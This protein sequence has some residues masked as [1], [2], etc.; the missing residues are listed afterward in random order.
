MADG[1]ALVVTAKSKEPA[2]PSGYVPVTV[3]VVVVPQAEGVTRTRT[4]ALGL[5]PVIGEAAHELPLSME[6]P[7]QPVQERV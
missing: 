4:G 2:V 1:F 5:T 3:A 6:S 7:E